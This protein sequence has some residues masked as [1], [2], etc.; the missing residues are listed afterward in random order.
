M[1]IDKELTF[2]EIWKVLAK[3]D[4][5][6]YTQEK[7]KLTYLSWARAWILLMKHHSESEY[8][9]HDFDG[10]PFRTLPDGT[11]E[12]VTSL[13]IGGCVRSM[14]LPIMDYKNNAVVNPSATQVNNN[15][16]RCLVKNIA[17]FGLGMGVYASLEPEDL[18]VDPE[19][20]LPDEKHDVKPEGKKTVAKKTKKKVKP[21]SDMPEAKE[22]ESLIPEN[23]DLAWAETFVFGMI[24][25][26]NI[27][28]TKEGL[29]GLW[30]DHEEQ[31]GLLK[32]KFPQQKS[33]LEG[34][35]VAKAK[36]IADE[37]KT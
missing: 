20:G 1:S 15:R 36:S 9:F 10:L 2:G 12:V 23:P 4:V 5:S 8:T 35:F 21:K 22:L 31:I 18:V 32:A 3:E 28:D 27:H 29:R 19:E 34:V 11:A 30:K 37:E 25:L 14:T 7:G 17:M 33:E 6:K 24:D 16:M 13:N 26:M